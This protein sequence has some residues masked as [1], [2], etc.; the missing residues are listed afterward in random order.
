MAEDDFAATVYG[1]RMT[2]G[3]FEEALPGQADFIDAYVVVGALSWTF[4]RFFENALTFELEGQIGK[5][6]GDQ[7]NME[8]NLPVVIRWSKFPCE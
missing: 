6:F 3:V 1:G 7:D 4:T 5:W 2:D 8:F